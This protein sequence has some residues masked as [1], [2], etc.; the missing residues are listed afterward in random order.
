MFVG[1]APSEESIE[2][3]LKQLEVGIP[4]DGLELLAIPLPLARG[5]YLALYR[6]AAKTGVD[7]WNLPS[8]TVREI[9]GSSRAAQFEMLRPSR[10]DADPPA[11]TS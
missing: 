10:L 6:A 9:L 5:D 4:A 8:Q 11:S 3:L 1:E 7:L 2:T